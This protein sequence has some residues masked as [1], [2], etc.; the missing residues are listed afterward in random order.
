MLGQMM[1]QPL[2]ISSLIS[3]AE[4]YHNDTEIVS[5]NAMDGTE[6]TTWG[7]VARNA[8]KLGSAL[9]KLG[10]GERPARARGARARAASRTKS[11]RGGAEPAR[12][13]CCAVGT[14]SER[15]G[16]SEVNSDAARP[17][18]GG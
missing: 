18:G 14:N 1:T 16:S 13:S 9:G 15:E 5:V 8:R 7:Q 10:D 2:L 4:R 12:E 11:G 17:G 6:V 3:H